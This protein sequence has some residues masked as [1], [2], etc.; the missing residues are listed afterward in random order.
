MPA[1]SIDRATPSDDDHR[2]DHWRPAL[3]GSAQTRPQSIDTGTD[4]PAMPKMLKN[5]VT[6][7]L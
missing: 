4:E 7:L 3:V 1:V 6:A 2:S 5:R